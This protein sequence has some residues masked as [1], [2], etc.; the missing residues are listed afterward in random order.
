MSTQTLDLRCAQSFEAGT[1]DK[2]MGRPLNYSFDPE[3]MDYS[4]YQ[5]GYDNGALWD[6]GEWREP[7]YYCTPG[8]TC[9]Y[10]GA[11]PE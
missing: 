10:C 7:D 6:D 8:C 3:K 11:E 5:R 2:G 1:E 9:W 4:E